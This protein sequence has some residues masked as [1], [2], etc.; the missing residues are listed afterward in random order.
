[1][2]RRCVPPALVQ[3]IVQAGVGDLPLGVERLATG[4][5]TMRAAQWIVASLWVVSWFF[6]YR[7]IYVWHHVTPSFHLNP[8]PRLPGVP[9]PHPG[10]FVLSVLVASATAPL[11]LL[12]LVSADLL[13]RRRTKPS[14]RG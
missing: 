13:R 11:V 9:P 7:E 12:V 10:L 1:M 3:V 8:P 2:L 14:F 4:R 5:L 6:L